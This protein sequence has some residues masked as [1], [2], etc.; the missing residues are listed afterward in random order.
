MSN[1]N[2]L[3]KIHRIFDRFLLRKQQPNFDQYMTS[4]K[5]PRNPKIVVLGG[6]FP[7]IQNLIQK[8][9]FIYY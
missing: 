6:Q 4:Y 1:L 2:A 5:F 8:L 7:L 3:L 9:S